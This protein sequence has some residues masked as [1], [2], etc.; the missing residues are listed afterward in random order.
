MKE[1]QQ[2]LNY[3]FTDISLLKLALT[4][5]SANKNNNERLEFLGDSILE[6]VITNEL[7]KR[8]K[9]IDEGKL[10]SLR[11]NLVKGETLLKLVTELNLAN[12]L[13]LGNGE[14]K[15]GGV[16]KQSIKENALEAIFGAIFIDSD[17]TTINKVILN[18]YQPLLNNI[19][20]KNSFKDP[21]T[22]LQEFLQKNNNK[23]PK[24]EVIETFGKSHNA[25]FKV[26]CSLPELQ[27]DIKQTASSIKKAEQSCAKELLKQ[28]NDEL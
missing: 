9:N 25:S 28:L 4:H 15:N 5:S 3:K 2:K 17:F 23:L 27:I 6:F 26:R 20:L 12:Y 24:Y 1:L 7:Y 21:K 13:I 18:L 22:R 11:S 16:Q 8:F 10:S 19:D 14:L